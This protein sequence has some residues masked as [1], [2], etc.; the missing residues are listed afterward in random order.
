LDRFPDNPDAFFNVAIELTFLNESRQAEEY[1]RKTI[2]AF[3]QFA[4]PK[5]TQ[6]LVA[7]KYKLSQQ[8][9]RGES[10][11]EAARLLNEVVEMDPN[12]LQAHLD[13]A[14][15]KIRQRLYQ[16]AR[17]HLERAIAL[18]PQSEEGHYLLA[19]AFS[20]AGNA[21]EAKRE[22]QKFSDLRAGRDNSVLMVVD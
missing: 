9:L 5:Y 7:A 14:R 12:Y 15:I 20:L 3:E 4:G 11:Q 8:L 18:N 17:R 10:Y 21:I 19:R 13:L 16:D 1:F 22:Y 2:D 6:T